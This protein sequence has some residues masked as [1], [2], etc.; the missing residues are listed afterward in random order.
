MRGIPGI[1]PQI[2][3]NVLQGQIMKD[4]KS[5]KWSGIVI[6]TIF[7]AFGLWGVIFQEYSSEGNRFR[8]GLHLNGHEAVITG[9]AILLTGLYILYLTLSRK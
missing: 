1:F 8:N 5:G 6:G 2:I 7:T 4:A 3:S 9:A